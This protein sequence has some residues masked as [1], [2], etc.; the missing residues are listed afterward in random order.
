MHTAALSTPGA[1]E[2]RRRNGPV[3]QERLRH[4]REE[5]KCGDIERGCCSIFWGGV[6]GG[7]ASSTVTTENEAQPEP[8]SLTIKLRKRKRN[9]RWS[10]RAHTVDNGTWGGSSKCCCI[11]EKPR[12]FGESSTE[13]EDDE[14]GCDSAHCIR[15]HK[16]STP[17]GKE[18][19]PASH[20]SAGSMQH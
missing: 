12:A 16:K 5:R 2:R 1:T 4:Q 20:D 11:Y 19:P 6:G 10:G 14:D 13:S 17:G 7:A 8:R 18:T 9:R 3:R 15:G